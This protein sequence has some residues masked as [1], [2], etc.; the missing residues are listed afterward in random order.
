MYGAGPLRGVD[1]QCSTVTDWLGT[2]TNYCME[3]TGLYYTNLTLWP[4]PILIL[5]GCRF[6]FSK[7]SC[8][9]QI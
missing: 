2:E 7:A 1:Y 5:N 9:G 3:T 4:Y 6:H 8:L